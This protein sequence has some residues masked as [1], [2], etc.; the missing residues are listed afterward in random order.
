[1]EKIGIVTNTSINRSECEALSAFVQQYD[2]EFKYNEVSHWH[3][4]K[5][6][7]VVADINAE[8]VVNLVK[9]LEGLD[10]CDG[11]FKALDP[12]HPL[13]PLTREDLFGREGTFFG[14]SASVDSDE[15]DLDE[16]SF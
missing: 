1:M 2:P 9:E 13:D 15:P 7:V 5:F 6:R 10:Y 16:P 12:D 14:W 11:V 4:D 3:S 8:D